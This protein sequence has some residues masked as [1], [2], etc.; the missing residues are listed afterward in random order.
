M[1]PFSADVSSRARTRMV[2]ETVAAEIAAGAPSSEVPFCA[3]V[4]PE[5]S[6][7]VR[8]NNDARND[9]AIA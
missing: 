1:A 3:V 2:L 5:K 4:L 7:T 8:R 6:A 9:G